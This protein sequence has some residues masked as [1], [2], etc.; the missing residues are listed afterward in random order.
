MEKSGVDFRMERYV[1]SIKSYNIL[2][3][4]LFLCIR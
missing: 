3:M 1:W 4:S 2:F